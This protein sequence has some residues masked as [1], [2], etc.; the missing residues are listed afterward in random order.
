MR[1]LNGS[2]L[3]GFIKERQAHQARGLIQ[4]HHV[5]PKLAIVQT[6]HTPVI[7]A[8]V[9]LKKAYG[10]DIHVI[11]EAHVIEQND[12]LETIRQLNADPTVHGIIVQL[13]V[14]EPSQTDELVNAVDPAKDVDGLGKSP[15][16]DPATP[17]AVNWLLAGYNVELRHKKIVVVGQ[18]RLVGTPLTRMFRDSGLTVETADV[19]TAD[20]GALTRTADVL[21]TATGQPGLI[22]SDM[23]M[24]SAVVVDAGVATDAGKMVGDLAEDVHMRSDLTMTPPKGGVG[25]L[26]VCALF[27][28]VIEAARRSITS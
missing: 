15:A 13:P 6:N 2:D 11:V 14:V 21:I 22:K 28:N 3:A 19:T 27:E 7:D 1:S 26:T 20:L 16:F 24:P 23:I 9:R 5:T 25:P 17:T 8:Y 4:A 12:A 18:G 10:A